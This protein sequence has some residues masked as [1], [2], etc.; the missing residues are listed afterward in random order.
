MDCSTPRTRNPDLWLESRPEFSRS[1]C[2]QLREWIHRWEPD[3]TES[4]KWNMLCFTGRKLVCGISGCQKHV[5][6]SFFRGV[7]L[8]DPAG[9]F[10]GGE[11]NTSIRSIRLTTLEGFSPEAL[12]KLLRA[13]VNLDLDPDRP[14]LPP[15]R[16]DPLPMPTELA[17]ALSANRKAAAGFANLAPTYRREYIVWISSAKRDETRRK[18]LAETI[19][20]LGRGLKWIDRKKA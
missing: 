17:E 20:A 11:N 10:W 7:E 2:A 3:L 1:L 4:I 8:P 16:R 19:A 18:R 13:A 6:L 12:R 9:L 5:A 14:P 15:R